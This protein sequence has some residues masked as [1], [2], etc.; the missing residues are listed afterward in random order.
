LQLNKGSEILSVV[1]KINGSELVRG[2]Y[3]IAKH[4]CWSFLKGGIVAN[5]SSPAEI[6]FEVK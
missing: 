3:V 2:G 6:F 1:F 5:Y 4:G